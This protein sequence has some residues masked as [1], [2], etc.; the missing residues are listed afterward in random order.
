VSSAI[1]VTVWARRYLNFLRVAGIEVADQLP[2]QF[3]KDRNRTI[4]FVPTDADVGHWIA[5]CAEVPDPYRAIA[6]LL[7]ATGF[8]DAE[9]TALK[10]DAYRVIDGRVI[11][12][13]VVTKNAEPR[14][15][16]LLKAGVA[17]FKRYIFE[18]RQSIE[19]PWLFP[20]PRNPSRH[21]SRKM[22]ETYVRLIRRNVNLPKATC[23][24]FRR[25]FAT[26]LVNSGVDHAVVAAIIGHSNLETLMKY[27]G[28]TGQALA[29]H[30][31][32]AGQ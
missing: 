7:P 16:P 4:R 23:H 20:L 5:C 1:T 3:P 26:R 30:V 19:S 32:D 2:S 13:A 25:Y 28:P 11:L 10:A 15:V 14:E 31:T 22:V 29:K 27:Y 9:I 21:V 6:A 18:Y 12:T 8:R 17:E 24:A